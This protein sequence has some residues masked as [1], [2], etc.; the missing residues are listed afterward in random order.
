[1]VT[2][3]GDRRKGLVICMLVQTGARQRYAKFR[4]QGAVTLFDVRQLHRADENAADYNG[5]M[6]EFYQRRSLEAKRCPDK[7]EKRQTVGTLQ[8]PES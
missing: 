8:W 6:V 7:L 3:F 5:L 4:I 2:C 1:M